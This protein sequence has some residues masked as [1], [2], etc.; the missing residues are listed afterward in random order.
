MASNNGNI[1]H[2]SLIRNATWKLAGLP[3][4]IAHTFNPTFGRQRQ[5][6]LCE[7]GASLAYIMS[8]RIARDLVSKQKTKNKTSQ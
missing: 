7:F 6:D 3:G 5:A 1:L 2:W 4:T 8:S